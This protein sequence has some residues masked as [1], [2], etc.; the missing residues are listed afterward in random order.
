MF[1]FFSII[2]F[3]LLGKI[4]DLDKFL[5]RFLFT[6]LNHLIFTL[7]KKDTKKHKIETKKLKIIIIIII[8]ITK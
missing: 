2:S 8:I 3:S 4:Y 5:Q 7:K 1:F 6:N